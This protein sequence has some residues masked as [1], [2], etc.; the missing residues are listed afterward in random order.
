MITSKA[1]FLCLLMTVSLTAIAQTIP[2]TPD[3]TVRFVSRNGDVLQRFEISDDASFLR[4]HECLQTMTAD[5]ENQLVCVRIRSAASPDGNT[6]GNRARSDQR[7]DDTRLYLLSAMPELERVPFVVTSAGED[8]EALCALLE[9]SDIPGADR[10]AEIIR[11]VP[12]WITDASGVVVDGRKKQLMDL[13]GGQTWNAMRETIFPQLQRTRVEFLFGGDSP[14]TSANDGAGTSATDDEETPAGA[15]R[16]YFRV[17]DTT[18]RP[19]FRNNA[20][21]L[22]QL[23]SMM[24]NRRYVTGDIIRVVGMASPEGSERLNNTLARRRAESLRKYIAAHWPEFADA[25]SVT[26]EGEAWEDFRAAV[27]AD[28][29]LSEA[30]SRRALDIIDSTISV[31]D[32]EAAL[33]KLTSWQRYYRSLYP[34]FRAASIET[35][36]ISDRFR[37]R[38]SELFIPGLSLELDAPAIE[39]RPDRLTVPTLT[40]KRYGQQKRTI[41]AVKTNLL[42]DAVTMLNYAI[43]IPIGDRFSLAWEH[44]FPW[45]V[46]RGNR[47]CIQY[48]TLGGEARWWFL[49]RP[50]PATEKRAQRDRLVGHFL[51]VYGLWGKT[52]LQWDRIGCYQCENIWSV[53]LTYGYAFPISRH[54]NLELSASFGYASIPYQRYIP[55]DDWQILWRDTEGSGIT[56]YFGPTK[57]QVSLVWPIQITTRA[58]EG[59]RR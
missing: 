55:S 6:D 16:I 25:V 53:G 32:K 2:G 7:A 1:I 22:E 30:D 51:G 59:A 24:D 29:K 58:R 38:D 27:Q 28:T 49:P 12:I 10:A 5:P 15:I 43:E 21:S 23:R 31:D 52:D 47:T 20:A 9:Q 35:D 56:Y 46:M 19:E 34:D 13:R 41:L 40:Q 8:Y 37:L 3:A 57:L 54:L 48:L 39:L 26:V 42:Y 45:W 14:I 33:R 18:I 44:Y 36:F 17:S 50:R 11:T 4:V